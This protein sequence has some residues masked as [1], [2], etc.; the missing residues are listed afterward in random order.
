[1]HSMEPQNRLEP[2]EIV[3]GRFQLRPPSLREADDILKLAD[4][5]A[6]RLWSPFRDVADLDGAREFC[7]KWSDWSGGKAALFLVFDATEGRTHG[8]VTLHHV[9][10][11]DQSAEIGFI[12]APW[13]RGHGVATTAVG[14]VLQWAFDSLDLVRIEL[15]HAVDNAPSCRV[16]DRLGFRLEGETRSSH[17]YGDGKLHNEHLHSRLVTD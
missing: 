15:L 4:D 17:R 13:A 16:A 1:M 9:D 5:P 14:S 7:R 6:T 3:A 11:R 8:L 12:T 10:P 2:V